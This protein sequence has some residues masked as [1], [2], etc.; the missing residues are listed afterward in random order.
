M[1]V[2]KHSLFEPTFLLR[3]PYAIA[4][5]GA[6]DILLRASDA[7]GIDHDASITDKNVLLPNGHTLQS[8]AAGHIRL[9]NMPNPFRACGNHSSVYRHCVHRDVL[10]TLQLT[11]SP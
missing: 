10:S 5:S 7:T 1:S 11:L 3:A 2:S 6:S 8:I 4:D 9:P